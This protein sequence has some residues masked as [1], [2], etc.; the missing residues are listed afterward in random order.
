M[1]SEM[2]WPKL[3]KHH[4]EIAWDDYEKDYSDLPAEVLRR[5]RWAGSSM[6]WDEAGGLAAAGAGGAVG[7]GLAARP[8]CVAVPV[9]VEVTGRQGDGLR[10]HGHEKQELE[11]RGGE[12]CARPPAC[13]VAPALA[14]R[15]RPAAPAGCVRPSRMRSGRRRR[16]RS[17]GATCCRWCWVCA[18]AR[19][20]GVGGH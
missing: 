5:H 2:W 3:F 6:R 4:G 20:L 7:A 16:E 19:V 14:Q 9:A 1:H 17:R 11:I 13:L 10:W 18:G 8:G 12:L 15:L